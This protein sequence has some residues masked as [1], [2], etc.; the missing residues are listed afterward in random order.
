MCSPGGTLFQ[1]VQV[2]RSPMAM[3][4]SASKLIPCIVVIIEISHVS[5][6]PDNNCV[7]VHNLKANKSI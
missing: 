2:S 7:Q 1:V 6:C 5:M 3:N 4:E